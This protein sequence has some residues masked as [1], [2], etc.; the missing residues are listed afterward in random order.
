M[1]AQ[2]VLYVGA[3][4]N[5]GTPWLRPRLLFP[6]FFMGFCSDRPWMFLQNLK[7][8]SLPVPEIIGGTQKIW[9]VPGYDH[10]PF[11]PK[12]LTGFYPEWPCKYIPKFEVRSFT[13]SWD[14]RGVA[15]LQTPNFE[16]GEAIGGRGWYYSKERWSVPISP[17]YILFLYQHLFARNFRFQFQLGLWTPDFGEGK[18]VFG[19]GDGIVRKR[20]GEFL[21]AVHSN[22]SSIFMRFRD[23]AAFVLQHATFSLPHSYSG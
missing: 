2:C 5:F 16:E 19:V 7:S 10:A 1:T 12:F 20:V 11:S 18:A 9:T 8:V 17:P 13:C 15:K 6:K 23:I 14:K 22:F 21:F 3:L 4:K